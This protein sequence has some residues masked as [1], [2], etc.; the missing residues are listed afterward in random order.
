MAIEYTYGNLISAT[1]AV[2]LTANQFQF[3]TL[4]TSGQAVLCSAITDL[5]IGIL[6]NA[7]RAGLAASIM[8]FGVSK[9]VMAAATAINSLIGTD[10]AAKGAIRVNGTDT[11]TYIVGRAIVA[12]AAANGVGSVA[13]SC[14]TPNRG[15]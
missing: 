1:A 3:V 4:N 2:D 13:F 8:T 5:P 6:Q 14:L 11:T 10:A 7:P 15:A 9:L 12:T